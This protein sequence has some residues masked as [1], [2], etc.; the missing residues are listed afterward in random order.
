MKRFIRNT[1][2]AIAL[3]MGSMAL[4]AQEVNTLYFLENAPMRS[5]FNPALMPVSSGYIIFTPLGYTSMWAGNNALSLSDMVYTKN[6]QTI[7]ALNQ[8]ETDKFLKKFHR[9]TLMSADLTTTILGFGAR[10]K[11][12][13]YFHGGIFLR[14]DAGLNIPKKLT[15]AMIMPDGIGLDLT[16]LN[17]SGLNF[18]MQ[19]YTEIMGGYTRPLN[20]QWTI[21]GKLKI[22]VGLFQA[23]VNVN[24]LTITPDQ[25]D[26]TAPARLNMAGDIR[27]AVPG[28]ID[29]TTILPAPGEGMFENIGD[30]VNNMLP[31]DMSS[32]PVSQMIKP[33]GI[34]AA[35]DFGFTWKP[36]K[37]LQVSAAIN[38]LGFIYWSNGVRGTVKG[39]MEFD[40][41]G[42][43][44]VKEKDGTIDTEG[45]KQQVT[46]HL[47]GY[48]NQIQ[49]EGL[50]GGYARMTRAHLNVGIDGLFWENRVG[51]GLLSQT[52]L[53]NNK[54]YEELT[55]GGFFR[56]VNW[57]N[58]QLLYHQW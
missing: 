14:M 33:A 31:S 26:P 56:P 9:N 40:G 3:L 17:M 18:G 30:R 15:S 10:T 32:I 6:G 53:Y 36:I 49:G 47:N 39:D 45:I 12:G 22:L 21:G 13:G 1:A 27:F 23:N 24:K 51:V 5:Q 29:P 37:Y 34:G 25:N 19:G 8:G 46:D 2:L 44:Q 57:F 54:I 58:S 42:E 16:N 41:I 48:L 7:T 50:P 38:D 11:K 52:K 28:I 43:I 35:I 20:D 4:F 55:L